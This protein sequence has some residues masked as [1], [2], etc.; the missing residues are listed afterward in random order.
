MPRGIYKRG[1]IHRNPH[2]KETRDKISIAHSGKILS[3]E[4]KEKIRLVKTGVKYPNRKRYSKGITPINKICLYCKKPFITNCFMP[5][6]M[7]CSQSCRSKNNLELNLLNLK[8]VDREYQKK[9]VSERKGE[10]HPL[11]IKDRT[12]AMENHRLRWIKESNDWRKSVF[13][14][15][16]FTCQDCGKTNCYIEAHHIKPW[17][18]NP[19]IRYDTKNGITLCRECHIKTFRKEEYFEEKYNKIILTKL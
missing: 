14:R 1:I 10:K 7:Y 3:A 19:E 12:K 8:K 2:S 15:D 11:W 6:K 18:N 4:T 9:I 17:R 13:H 5:K 16:D